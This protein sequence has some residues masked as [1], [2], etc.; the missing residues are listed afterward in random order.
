M[1]KEEDKDW[2]KDWGGE[3]YR[4]PDYIEGLSSHG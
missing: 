1:S 2:M 4:A 3:L